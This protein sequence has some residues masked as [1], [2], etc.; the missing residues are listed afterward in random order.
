MF[1]MDVSDVLRDRMQEPEG[2]QRMAFVSIAAHIVVFAV[3]VFMPG[4]LLS[5][6]GDEPKTIMTIS[7]SG[8]GEGTRSGGMTPIGGRPVQTTEPAEKREALRPPAAKPPEM[9]LPTKV[10]KPTKASPTPEVRQAPDEAKGRTLA[11]GKE[12]SAGSAIA[13]T[14]A[15]GQGF[16]LSSGGGVGSG[17]YLDVADFCCPDYIAQMIERIRANWQVRPG[18]GTVSVKFTIRRDGSIDNVEVE[19]SSGNPILDLNAQKAVLVTRTLNPLPAAFS[20][21]TLG[22]HLTFQYQ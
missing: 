6:A 8:S 3:I 1:S 14:G 12:L 20:N 11:R 9:T 17:S 13:E 19:R 18:P 16:G 15:R 2:L 5:R 7:L 21:P 22:V 4:G 10:T